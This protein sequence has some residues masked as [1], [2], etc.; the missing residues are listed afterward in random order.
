VLKF[1]R[2]SYIHTFVD[3]GNTAPIAVLSKFRISIIALFDASHRAISA[4]CL[5]RRSSNATP[6]RASQALVTVRGRLARWIKHCVPQ[7]SRTQLAVLQSLFL[8]IK[9][10]V[11]ITVVR[12]SCTSAY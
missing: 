1:Y 11:F 8:S 7:N 12:Q 5:P 3:I 4:F 2:Y 6:S 9:L 10:K